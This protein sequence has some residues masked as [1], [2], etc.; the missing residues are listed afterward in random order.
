MGQGTQGVSATPDSVQ[1]PNVQ[2]QGGTPEVSVPFPSIRTELDGHSGMA[3]HGEVPNPGE[4]EPSE[5]CSHSRTLRHSSHWR[6]SKEHLRLRG[7][8]N[9]QA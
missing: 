8:F 5:H 1:N 3:T 4:Y 7:Q 9:S 2:T 6:H